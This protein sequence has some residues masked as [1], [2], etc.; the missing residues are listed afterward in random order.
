MSILYLCSKADLTAHAG[1]VLTVRIEYARDSVAVGVFADGDGENTLNVRVLVCCAVKD[2]ISCR[3]TNIES[4][5]LLLHQP[6]LMYMEGQPSCVLKCELCVP[7]I[8]IK[9]PEA[10]WAACLC[11]ITVDGVKL[12]S[13]VRQFR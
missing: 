1:V 4:L 10:S 6:L 11:F 2:Q 9:S 13:L 7:G 8:S 3:R 12:K 5:T